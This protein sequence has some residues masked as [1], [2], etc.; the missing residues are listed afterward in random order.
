MKRLAL[1][2]G[3]LA[4]AAPLV[5]AQSSTWTPD[6]VH[7]V[8]SFSV[9][10]LSIAK[11]RGHFGTVSG[12]IIIDPADI[13]KSSVDMTIDVAGV[14]TGNSMRDTD[15]KSPN[16]FDVSKFPK[17]IFVSTSVAEAAGGLTVT[18]NLTLHGVTR[19]VVLHVEGPTGPITS[20]DQKEHEGFSATA[21]FSRTDFGIG[22][23][24][25]DKIVGDQVN[26]ILDMDIVKQ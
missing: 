24:Y 2:G 25:P 23:G 10:H 15:L 26:L 11:V 13:A 19:P 3:I 18:G 9:L 17:A 7:S 16:F 22:P 8:V 20:M 4:L 6:P 5:S 21:S 1:L 14:D 12:K